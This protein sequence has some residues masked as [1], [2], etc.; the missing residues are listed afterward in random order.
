MTT[1]GS[2]PS[3]NTVKNMTVLLSSLFI[4]VS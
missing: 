4:L 3:W 1:N 2:R